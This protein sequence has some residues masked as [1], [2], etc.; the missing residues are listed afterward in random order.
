MKTRLVFFAFS[1]L[2]SATAAF[3]QA[4]F[5]VAA[6]NDALFSLAN[7]RGPGVNQVGLIVDGGK[8]SALSYQTQDDKGKVENKTF[9]IAA[10]GTAD[11]AVLEE[12]QGVKAL[13]VLGSIDSAAGVGQV[14]FRYIYNGLT[15]RYKTCP[16]DLK[17]SSAG[18]WTLFNH[19]TG[20]PIIGAKMITWSLG[21]D[22]LQGIC[23]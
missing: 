4:E 13:A 11:G 10:L 21:I 9:P 23:P 5:F 8:V 12:G 20:T 22:T 15:G 6:K 3:A 19:T 1:V 14:T 2:F 16:A 7:D 18:D 17:R